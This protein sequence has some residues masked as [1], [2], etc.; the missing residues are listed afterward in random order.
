MLNLKFIPQINEC[1]KEIV[2]AKKNKKQN[3]YEQL[4]KHPN[5]DTKGS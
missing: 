1:S 2:K 5:K 4:Y 3:I